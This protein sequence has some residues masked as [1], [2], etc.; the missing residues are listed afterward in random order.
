M[1]GRDLLV[2][3]VFTADGT[4]DVY[5]PT[6][7]WTNWFTGERVVEVVVPSGESATYRVVVDADGAASVAQ[8]TGARVTQVGR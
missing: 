3:P 1:L 4:V 7:T 6:G 8:G 5:L 2:A